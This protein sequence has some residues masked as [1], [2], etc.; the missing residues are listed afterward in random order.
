MSK[1]PNLLKFMIPLSL[2][3]IFFSFSVFATTEQDLEDSV[4]A[5]YALEESAFPYIDS[6]NGVD[7]ITGVATDRVTDKINY[8]QDF[9]FGGDYLQ[10]NTSTIFEM[11]EFTWN[12]WHEPHT[13]GPSERQQILSTQ[14]TSGSSHGCYLQIY[15]INETWADD[16]LFSCFN[17]TGGFNTIVPDFASVGTKVMI[18]VTY[19]GTY[20]TIYKNGVEQTNYAYRQKGGDIAYST[21][22]H[23]LETRRYSG[24]YTPRADMDEISIYNKA[25]SQTEIDFLY[26]SN[27][28]D[29]DQQYH[30][31]DTILSIQ[32]TNPANE[33][34]TNV[35]EPV[36]YTI[37]TTGENDTL[38]CYLYIDSVLN[39]TDSFIVNRVADK[40]FNVTWMNGIHQFHVNCTSAI[41]PMSSASFDFDYDDRE[42]FVMTPSPN[43]FN[44]TTFS[45][46]SMNIYGNV[47]DDN[48]ERINLT[49]RYPNGTV[50]W[51]NDSGIVS[52]TEYLWDETFNT[53]PE[54]NGDWSMEIWAT[55]GI[56]D[57]E[58][59][60]SFTVANCVPDW[61]C[62]SFTT[63]NT[64]DQQLCNG[65]T[66]INNCS[67][68]Y[69]GDYSE[70]GVLPCDYCIAD[71]QIINQSACQAQTQDTCYIDDNFGTCC[72]VTGFANDCYGGIVQ[73]VDVYCEYD[74]LCTLFDYHEEDLSASIL[75]TATKFL[76]VVGTFVFIFIIGFGISYGIRK[77]KLR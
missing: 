76:V 33:T 23:R 35:Q 66:D 44:T 46:Y 21:G 17:S 63:C 43:T 11:S 41:N 36:Q 67:Y 70:F 72:N 53:T 20:A 8:G 38:N 28:P 29:S 15:K 1:Q 51:N 37:N 73:T 47:T 61:S 16:L 42:P 57:A 12:I 22:N 58:L 3:L 7:F 65:V 14:P 40:E 52:L 39:Q 74:V 4:V 49:L 27:N 18:T 68:P 25:L 26:A 32:I 77:Y 10:T 62:N 54:D 45:G 34:R 50:F 6:V 55:D 9:G 31:I 75:S 64:T 5:Y 69:S 30:F 60:I 19:N 2:L 59:S 56:N 71:I 48:L 24:A 13:I